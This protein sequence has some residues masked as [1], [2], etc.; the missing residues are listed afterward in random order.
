MISLEDPTSPL[1]PSLSQ[2][3]VVILKKKAYFS[4]CDQYDLSV[5]KS[6]IKPKW[7]YD[8]FNYAWTVLI[9]S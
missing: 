8:R 4:L 3:L 9:T 1:V 2:W 7:L 5:I 6:D